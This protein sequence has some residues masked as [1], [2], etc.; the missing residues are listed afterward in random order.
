[1]AN[2]K[3]QLADGTVLMDLTED[4][5]TPETL[6]EGTTAHDAAGNLIVGVAPTDAVRYNAQTL[7]EEQKTQARENI[8]AGDMAASTYDPQGRNEDVFRLIDDT[9]GYVKDELEDINSG[10]TG[11]E[12]GGDSGGMSYQIG[13][14]LKVVDNTLMVD[15]VDN[16][17]GDNSLPATA[18]LVQS[19]VGNIEILLAA[20]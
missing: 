14:G 6:A 4:T 5:V 16:F 2:S 12:A 8:S 19:T 17:E 9:L 18:A 3:V 1:M 20:L 11:G 7:T 13:Y 10:D 15:S